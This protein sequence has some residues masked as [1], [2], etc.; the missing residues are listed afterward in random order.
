MPYYLY[1]DY[2]YSDAL[3]L[4]HDTYEKTFPTLQDFI[5]YCHVQ[6][7]TVFDFQ[8]Y[9]NYF[10]SWLPD[11]KHT[12]H[13]K[14]MTSIMQVNQIPFHVPTGK[15]GYKEILYMSWLSEKMPRHL[16]HYVSFAYLVDDNGDKILDSKYNLPQFIFNPEGW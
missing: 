9:W 3:N 4:I 10:D 11:L 15:I 5:N 13:H 16:I 12:S 7:I 1:G 8:D 14:Y 6:K 2:Y